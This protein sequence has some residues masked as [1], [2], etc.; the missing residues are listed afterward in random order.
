MQ[1]FDFIIGETSERPVKMDALTLVDTRLLGCCNSGGGKSWMLRALVEQVG[2]R[3]PTIVLDPEGEFATLRERLDMVLVG[4]DGD[5]DPDPRSAALLC[6]KL[7][8][9]RLSAVVDLYDLRLDQRRA[10]VRTFIEALIDL[11]RKLWGPTLVV[12][13]EAHKFAPEKGS[14][15]AESTDAVI[16][17]MSQGRKRGYGGILVTQR[18]SK[19]HKDAVGECN[20]VMI[21]RCVQDVD[22]KRSGDL[23]GM[24][25]QD[26]GLLR[27]LRPGEFH[28]FGPAFTHDGIVLF[29]TRKCDTTHPDARTRHR[30]KPPAP[31]KAILD[32]LPELAD[33]PARA[34]EE[35]ATLEAATAEV[36]RLTRELAK[37]RQ[38]RPVQAAPA[39]VDRAQVRAVAKTVGDRWREAVRSR[40]ERWREILRTRDERWRSAVHDVLEPVVGQIEK[41]ARLKDIDLALP[42]LDL[43]P[44]EIAKMEALIATPPPPTKKLREL[45]GGNNGRAAPSP[46]AEVSG[47]LSPS[48]SKILAALAQFDDGLT[49]RRLGTITGLAMRGGSFNKTMAMLRENAYVEGGRGEPLRITAAGRAVVGEPEPLP[50]GPAL[51]DHWRAK[52]RNRSAETIFDAFVQHGEL[53]LH[54]L[55]EVTGLATRGGSFNKA[56]A[57]IRAMGLVQGRGRMRLDPEL[58]EHARG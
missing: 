44:E 25:A 39:T 34:A 51:L 19:L 32:V 3:I 8:E 13:D 42:V 4:S 37:A 21:G 38:A 10:F 49:L 1:S 41:G 28:G 48:A 6:R 31:S 22:I 45:M 40:D 54:E 7:V 55:G 2:S 14:G 27:S 43:S 46:R 11:P 20:N 57:R 50:T 26:R 9:L 35:R 47:D 30:I 17:L 56:M 36:E 24:S 18:L 53:S 33:L 52:L 5:V 29:R 23:L 12:L 15:Q 58:M 16:S